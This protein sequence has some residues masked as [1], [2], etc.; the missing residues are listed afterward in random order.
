MRE[1]AFLRS[2]I[3]VSLTVGIYLITYTMTNSLLALAEALHRV[4]DVFAMYIAWICVRISLRPPDEEHPYGHEKAE[5]IGGF[6]VS[7]FIMGVCIFVAYESIMGLI[8]GHELKGEPLVIPALLSA[9]VIDVWRAFTLKRLSGVL[10]NAA[11]SHFI[12]DASITSFTLALLSFTIFMP[13]YLLLASLID[14]FASLVIACSFAYIGVRLLKTSISELMDTAVK[15]LDEHVKKL[16]KGVP[17]VLDV[18]SVRTR[19]VG[20][21]H[22]IEVTVSVPEHISVAEAHEIAGKVEARLKGAFESPIIQVHVEPEQKALFKLHEELEPLGVKN[23]KLLRIDNVSLILIALAQNSAISHKD[24]EALVNRHIPDAIVY[25]MRF[26][27]IGACL[28]AIRR[29]C[30]E[31]GV[32]CISMA[33]YDD[34]IAIEARNC[35]GEFWDAIRRL[36]IPLRIFVRCIE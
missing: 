15:G 29:A 12:L 32:D 27:D 22:H 23:V 1:R 13:Q 6:V 33:I 34:I 5:S 16:A 19:R 30:L 10:A 36:G 4:L 3:A 17:G 31:A 26:P 18:R 21:K 25:I 24:V 28:E 14:V 8:K 35:K 20:H 2:F 7:M 9:L 11:A